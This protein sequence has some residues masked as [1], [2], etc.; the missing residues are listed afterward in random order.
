MPG[1]PAVSGEHFPFCSG[2]CREVDLYRWSVGSY[3]IVE[4]V[5]PEVA[6]FLKDDPNI[7]VQDE[8]E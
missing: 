1:N 8:G 3:A 4:D 2:R 6:E 7:H 5:D